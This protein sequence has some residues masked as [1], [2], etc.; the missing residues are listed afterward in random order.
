MA[1]PGATGVRISAQQLV[2]R[3]LAE[4][5][6]L[7]VAQARALLAQP[8]VLA[9]DLREPAEREREGAIPGAFHAPRGV[10]EFWA[11]PE[12]DWHRPELAGG[13]LLL[14][15]CGIGWRSALAA[16]ALQQMGLPRVAHL[17]GGFAAWRDAGA[18]V[19]AVAAP[20]ARPAPT[21]DP[22]ADGG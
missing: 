19:Q 20:R 4:V 6:T 1:T 18:P 2:Q 5:T 11:C 3:A 9:V 15:Y 16:Q 14:L 10:L 21:G 8:D 17:G 13:R 12:S 22:Q 7:D